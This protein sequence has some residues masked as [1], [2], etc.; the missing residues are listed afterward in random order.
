M[1][2]N[3]LVGISNTP[4]AS[5]KKWLNLQNNSF[6]DI[7]TFKSFDRLYFGQLFR[8]KS[9]FFFTNFSPACNFCYIKVSIVSVEWTHSER[10]LVTLPETCAMNIT[11]KMSTYMIWDVSIWRKTDTIPT[12]LSNNVFSEYYYFLCAVLNTTW[13]GSEHRTRNFITEVSY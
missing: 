6:Y 3:I 4:H 1:Q 12:H 9:D 7:C 8:R 11:R 13:I 10:D 5:L 2:H